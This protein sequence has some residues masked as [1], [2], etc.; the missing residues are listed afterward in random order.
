[1]VG[2]AQTLYTMSFSCLGCLAYNSLKIS[3]NSYNLEKCLKQVVKEKARLVLKLHTIIVHSPPP[4]PHT[5]TTQNLNE[6]LPGIKHSVTI[7]GLISQSWFWDQCLE[8]SSMDQVVIWCKRSF[9]LSA[10]WQSSLIVILGC[11]CA[12]KR[13]TMTLSQFLCEVR[14]LIF[15]IFGRLLASLH[16]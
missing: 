15:R 7:I 14:L 12:K 1:M 10:N 2:I 9:Q 3:L 11:H 4:T 6:G 16:I 5:H 13:I 8:F